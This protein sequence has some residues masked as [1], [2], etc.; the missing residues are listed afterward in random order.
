[1]APERGRSVNSI[2]RI[3]GRE[4][5]G[6]DRDGTVPGPDRRPEFPLSPGRLSWPA[7]GLGFR[8]RCPS[9]GRGR[10]FESYLRVVGAC[11]TCGEELARFRADD[12]P[13]Y[14][15]I[16]IV[17]HVAV[18]GLLLLE[19]NMTLPMWL[20]AALFVPGTL[21]ATLMLLP[22]VKGAL[23][24]LHWSLGLRMARTTRGEP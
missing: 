2:S 4:Q 24:G 23:V 19:Q 10:L 1:M 8:R 7:L 6:I 3:S 18:F 14:F 21:I 16:A 17:G 15:T 11:E 22:R 12:A 5:A 20:L 9:C 13:A